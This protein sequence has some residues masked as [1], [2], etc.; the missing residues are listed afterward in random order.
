MLRRL[1]L[2]ERILEYGAVG[3]VDLTVP[4]PPQFC[5]LR[6]LFFTDWYSS[7]KQPFL[8]SHQTFV[9]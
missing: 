3:F 9:H 1:R 8:G 2:P 5:R 6:L 4:A 7:P